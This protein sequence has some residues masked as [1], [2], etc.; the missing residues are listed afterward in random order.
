MI[1]DLTLYQ[2]KSRGESQYPWDYYKRV[3]DIP[4]AA[5]F[6]PLGE[7]GCP[8]VKKRQAEP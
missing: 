7:G 1:Y 3:R 5:A 4:A 8:L 2:V 6:R